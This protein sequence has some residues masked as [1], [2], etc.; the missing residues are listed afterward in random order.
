MRAICCPPS[1]IASGTARTLGMPVDCCLRAPAHLPFRPSIVHC[2]RIFFDSKC[3][4][5]SRGG[6][7]V[8]PSDAIQSAQLQKTSQFSG[9]ALTTLRVRKLAVVLQ[10]PSSVE[11]PAEFSTQRRSLLELTVFPHHSCN[12]THFLTI[13]LPF[14]WEI[15]FVSL[16]SS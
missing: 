11:M 7:F 6:N 15:L 16:P 4:K 13:T 12:P 3:P 1:M 8:R 5:V 9:T 2:N 10:L 14:L